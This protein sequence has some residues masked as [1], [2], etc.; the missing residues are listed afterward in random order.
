M[1]APGT[2]TAGDLCSG[3]GLCCHGWVFFQT[4]LSPAEVHSLGKLTSVV[5]TTIGSAIC[6][7]CAL[8][9]GTLCGVYELRPVVCRDY[10]CASLTAVARGALSMDDARARLE[11]ARSAMAELGAALVASGWMAPGD[12][13]VAA[14]RKFTAAARHAPDL[15]AFRRTHAQ[16]LLA[17]AKAS[18]IGGLALGDCL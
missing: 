16:V 18:V 17:G 13:G 8:N 4:L 2:S 5:Q 9:T 14:W 10:S 12:A 6:Q 3:C 11:H 7:P 15:V 1:S